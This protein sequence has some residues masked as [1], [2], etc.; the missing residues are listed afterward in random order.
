MSVV[1]LHL[2]VPTVYLLSIPKLPWC[3]PSNTQ[4]H[5]PPACGWKRPRPSPHRSHP[6]FMCGSKW[7]TKKPRNKI[8]YG[9]LSVHFARFFWGG[10]TFL[11]HTCVNLFCQHINKRFQGSF[12]IFVVF[13]LVCELDACLQILAIISN[14]WMHTICRC[15]ILYVSLL[16][17]YWQTHKFPVIQSISAS[18]SLGLASHHQ[19]LFISIFIHLTLLLTDL[20]TEKDTAVGITKF[21]SE[22]VAKSL[23]HSSGL[24]FQ[25]CQQDATD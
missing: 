12:I 5:R 6:R 25:S 16:F 4:L 9:N 24:Q 23:R 8:Y 21:L 3:K 10:S 15:R 18:T 7:S 19:F 22:Q 20:L 13:L 1:Y 11:R 2:Q 14:S 17:H